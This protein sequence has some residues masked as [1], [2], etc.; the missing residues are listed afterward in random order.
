MKQSIHTWKYASEWEQGAF[1]D[2]LRYLIE[3]GYII[4]HITVITRTNTELRTAVV[5]CIRNN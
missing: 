5:V 4:Q 2:W 1:D 3:Q